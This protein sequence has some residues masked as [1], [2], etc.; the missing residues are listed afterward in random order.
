MMF[1][2]RILARAACAAWLATTC[3]HAQTVQT[4]VFRPGGA[5]FGG[6]VP[7]SIQAVDLAAGAVLRGDPVVSSWLPDGRV[8]DAFVRGPEVWAVHDGGLV[9]LR[10]SDLSLIAESVTDVR[11]RAIVSTPSGGAI[12]FGREA[13]NPTVAVA[14][15]VDAN[16]GELARVPGAA[17]VVR[18]ARVGSTLVAVVGDDVVTLDASYRAVGDFSPEAVAAVVASGA[19]FF[20]QSVAVHLGEVVIVTFGGVART[21]FNGSLIGFSGNTTGPFESHAAPTDAGD[22]VVI[23]ANGLQ[24]LDRES[25]RTTQSISLF[26]AGPGVPFLTNEVISQSPTSSRICPSAPNSSGRPGALSLVATDDLDREILIAF[27]RG[28]PAGQT[29]QFFYGDAVGAVP[30]GAGTICVD[31]ATGGLVR[32]TLG[33]STAD[34]TFE[35]RLTFAAPGSGSEFLAGTTW[36]FQAAFRDPGQGAGFGTTD[37]V[38]LTFR[39]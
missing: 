33:A 34:G 1:P 13:A 24:I 5:V 30:F 39:P 20:P 3:A 16:G 21:D 36:V 25:G 37:A 15:E 11:M 17:D 26:P 12:C 38:T 32:S 28:I 7:P 8:R 27:A 6:A 18:A 19:A 4:F 31:P 14:V 10:R 9:R 29:T 22:L 23:T 2:E 35:T